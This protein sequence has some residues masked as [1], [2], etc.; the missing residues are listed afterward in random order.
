MTAPATHARQHLR[1]GE[2]I[3]RDGSRAA[4][5]LDVPAQVAAP[6]AEGVSV[7]QPAVFLFVDDEDAIL[8]ALAR[9]MNPR[10]D[11]IE[12]RYAP[13]AERALEMLERGDIDVVATDIKMPGLDGLSLLRRVKSEHPQVLR[14]AICTSFDGPAQRAMVEIGVAR[15]LEKPWHGVELVELVETL[16]DT[17]QQR[18]AAGSAQ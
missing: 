18:R 14:V 8:R 15:V 17:V 12:A 11:H 16:A 3:P 2:D 5:G 4:S 9:W 6:P 7:R 1:V 10:A 13:S